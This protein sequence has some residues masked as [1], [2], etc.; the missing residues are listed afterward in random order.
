MA[1]EMP[2]CLP[3]TQPMH[4]L[5]NLCSALIIAVVTAL[6]FAQ[7]AHAERLSAN[8]ATRDVQFI[9][10]PDT[11]DAPAD[12]PDH[13]NGDLKRYA[14]RY[15]EKRI[16]ILLKFRELDRSEPLLVLGGAFRF[17]GHGQLNYSEAVVKAR[18]GSWAG[19]ARMSNRPKCAVNHRLD[20]TKNQ[21]AISF[22]AGCFGSPRWLQFNAVAITTD[23][24]RN[25]TYI[26]ADRAPGTLRRERWTARTRQG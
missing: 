22:P 21:V 4:R 26:Y 5:R 15:G 8:D 1:P 11:P 24:W 9:Q 2:Y 12:A 10:P 25:P 13:A 23:R 20:Y 16:W 3:V 7:P 17:P 18:A 14:I 6:L 19:S